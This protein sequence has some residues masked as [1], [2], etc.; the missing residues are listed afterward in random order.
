MSYPRAIKVNEGLDVGNVFAAD[1]AAPVV[2]SATRFLGVT[3]MANG[4]YTLVQTASS[5]G[6][7]RTVSVTH[8]ANG[9]ADTLGTIL[10]TGTDVDGK[11]I[12][13]TVTPGSGTTVY[14][15]KAFKTLVSAVQ[16][17][18]VQAGGATDTVSL[19]V[20][21][22][23]GL[24]GSILRAKPALSSAA[25]IFAGFL[26]GAIQALTVT[27]DATDIAKCTVDGSAGTYNGTKRLVALIRR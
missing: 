21:P 12:T 18:W 20:G 4:A 5:D 9:T 1:L 7:A 26:G 14:S 6:L 16:A 11:T 10:L 13:E 24:P 8:A 15:T 22:A 23:I 17:G 19:G 25:Q 27:F 2:A 3:A